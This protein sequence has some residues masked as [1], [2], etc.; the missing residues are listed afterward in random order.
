MKKA[1][2]LLV[3]MNGAL[4]VSDASQAIIGL[5]KLWYLQKMCNLWL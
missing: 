1:N 5:G 4:L 2:P 3:H